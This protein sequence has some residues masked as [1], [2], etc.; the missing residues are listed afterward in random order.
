MTKMQVPLFRALIQNCTAHRSSDASAG[1]ALRFTEALAKSMESRTF[2]PRTVILAKG[3][4]SAEIVF[5]Y[6]GQC[7]VLL[8]LEDTPIK[9]LG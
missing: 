9:V 6:T 8:E 5:P 3:G 2:K 4:I 7:E 1:E